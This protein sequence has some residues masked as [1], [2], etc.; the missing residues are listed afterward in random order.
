M[1]IIRCI[2]IDEKIWDDTRVAVK[3]DKTYISHLIEGLLKTHLL[4]RA[5]AMAS[6]K[7]KDI[8]QN[9]MSATQS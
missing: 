3:E 4:D 9:A 5:I 7:G 6:V 1:R 8:E 2:R